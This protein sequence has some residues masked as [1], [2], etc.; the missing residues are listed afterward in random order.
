MGNEHLSST[1]VMPKAPEG[2]PGQQGWEMFL[3]PL[4]FTTLTEAL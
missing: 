2:M 3:P 1:L 4:P